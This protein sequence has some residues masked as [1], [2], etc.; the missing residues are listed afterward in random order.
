MSLCFWR[1]VRLKQLVILVDDTAGFWVTRVILAYL[2]GVCVG[3]HHALRRHFRRIGDYDVVA[4]RLAHPASVEARQP[5][6][7]VKDR[8]RLWEEVDVIRMVEGARQFTGKFKVW[9]LVLAN[10]HYFRAVDHDIGGHQ[11]RITQQ[12][13][14]H[15]VLEVHIPDHLFDGRV[16]LDPR[17]GRDHRQE[18]EQI[19]MLRHV[20]LAED[21]GFL[22]VESR[23]QPVEGHL[24][25]VLANRTTLVPLG[26]QSVHVG[27]HEVAVILVLQLHVIRQYAQIVTKVELASWTHATQNTFFHGHLTASGRYSK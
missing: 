2:Q 5:L 16:A 23:P 26:G 17:Y 27:D 4:K 15:V 10:W 25:P 6:K 8:L 1:G 11:D 12:A 13:K 24:T 7:L 9:D 22:R 19:G 14:V 3:R 18:R 21:G 20:G